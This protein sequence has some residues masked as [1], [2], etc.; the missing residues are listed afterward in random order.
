MNVSVHPRVCRHLVEGLPPGFLRSRIGSRRY[1]NR[2]VEWLGW[3]WVRRLLEQPSC[4][5]RPLGPRRH[6]AHCG[7][8]T[9]LAGAR[10]S[11][12]R[13]R[14][15]PRS[16]D[17]RGARDARAAASDRVDALFCRGR[18]PARSVDTSR[19]R[20]GSPVAKAAPA[21]TTPMSGC[22]GFSPSSRLVR[23]FCHT[24]ASNPQSGRG[25]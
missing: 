9:D 1:G 14:P 6:R 4:R 22:R 23:D 25:E 19:G 21:A 11:A 16:A 24:E 13:P 12:L 8:G 7:R 3:R 10:A 15:P 5:D 20:P 2:L 18:S 17:R